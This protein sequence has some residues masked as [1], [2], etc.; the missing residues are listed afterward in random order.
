MGRRLRGRLDRRRRESELAWLISVRGDQW[1]V[2]NLSSRVEERCVEEQPSPPPSLFLQPQ[3]HFQ[4][5]LRLT[6]QRGDER[7]GNVMHRAD[8]SQS[9]SSSL[10]GLFLTPSTFRR[11]FLLHLASDGAGC[12][13]NTARRVGSPCRRGAGFFSVLLTQL[14]SSTF[15]FSASRP[16]FSRPLGP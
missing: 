11:P 4:L 9:L 1:E 14:S 16:L 10:C 7:T 8:G 15:D 6:P 2:R 12:Q 3:P 5:G 13:L